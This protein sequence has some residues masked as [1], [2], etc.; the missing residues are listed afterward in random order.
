MLMSNAVDTYSTDN[1]IVDSGADDAVSTR[2]SVY[3]PVS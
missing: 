1:S 3:I 2:Q